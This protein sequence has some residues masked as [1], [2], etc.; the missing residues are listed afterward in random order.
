[1]RQWIRDF[2]WKVFKCDV[3]DAHYNKWWKEEAMHRDLIM[4]RE[5]P[6]F[7][8][9]SNPVDMELLEWVNKY[10]ADF[11]MTNSECCALRCESA[12]GRFC[13]WG[14]DP[15]EAVQSA[16]HDQDRKERFSGASEVRH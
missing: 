16:I 2:L 15:R 13:G 6:E 3:D 11:E 1:M 10:A 7:L 4:T 5:L 12:D 8:A 14:D 9:S